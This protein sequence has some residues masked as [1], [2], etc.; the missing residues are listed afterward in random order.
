[1]KVITKSGANTIP[2]KDT[3]GDTNQTTHPVESRSIPGN[4]N[5]VNNTA[6]TKAISTN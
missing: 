6:I 2:A 3:S 4:T 1:M 5:T